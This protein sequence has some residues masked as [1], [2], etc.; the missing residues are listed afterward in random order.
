MDVFLGIVIGVII[1]AVYAF[2][3]WALIEVL[4][5][6]VKSVLKWPDRPQ[7]GPSAPV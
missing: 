4:A 5:G 6:L 7:S 2:G 3:V 1:F